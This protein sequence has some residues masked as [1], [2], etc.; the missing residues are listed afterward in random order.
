MEAMT[1]S[2]AIEYLKT[3]KQDYKLMIYG[4]GMS[5]P[6]TEKTI[7]EGEDGVYII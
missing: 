6:F 7:T 2:E 1:V 3:L 4:E 5:Y